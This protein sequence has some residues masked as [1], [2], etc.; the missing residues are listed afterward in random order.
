[1]EGKQ[2]LQPGDRVAERY[3]V[4]RLLATGGMGAVYVA[5]HSDLGTEVAI[6]VLSTGHDDLTLATRFLREAR[7][8][9]RLK[10]EHIARVFDFGVLPSGHPFMA[11][12]LLAGVDVDGVLELGPIPVQ[13]AVDYVLQAC[14]GLAVAHAAG[15]VHRDIKPSNLFV[16]SRSDGSPLIKILDFGIAKD[17]SDSKKTTGGMGSPYYMSPEQVRAA[18]TVDAR[19]DVWALG[20]TLYEMLSCQRPF[21]GTIASQVCVAIVNDPPTPLDSVVSGLPPDLVA[22]IHR[23]LEK[24]VDD[25]P[26]GV[27]ELAVL[28]APFASPEGVLHAER[29]ARISTGRTSLV[30]VP[31]SGAGSVPPG[32]RISQSRHTPST[33]LRRVTPQNSETMPALSSRPPPPRR[34]RAM[35]G[36]FVGLAAVVILVGAAFVVR[37]RADGKSVGASLPSAISTMTASPPTTTTVVEPTATTAPSTVPAPDTASAASASTAATSTT[38]PVTTRPATSSKASPSARPGATGFDGTEDRN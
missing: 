23:C 28:L 21:E 30:S 4:E 9:A 25:R 5:V 38:K 2:L 8:A 6:K 15:I 19:T 11:L 14:E 34:S 13:S 22:I 31:P 17:A 20:V 18:A 12:E 36:V 32:D 1:M 26:A 16:T 29:A 27:G 10:S 35:I 7:S 3:V 33:A 24:K 37:D